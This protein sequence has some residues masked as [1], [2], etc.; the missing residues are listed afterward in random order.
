MT[1]RDVARWIK[2]IA[3]YVA[4]RIRSGQAESAAIAGGIADYT[5]LLDD[6][7]SQQFLGSPRAKL[8]AEVLTR[9]VW[10]DA[11]AAKA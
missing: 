2:A 8:A 1:T 5:A 6:M 11:Q 9:R 3:P 7:T 4:D 10:Q